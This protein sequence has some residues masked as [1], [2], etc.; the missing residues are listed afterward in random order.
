VAEATA[1]PAVM[2]AA[3]SQTSSALLAAV[4]TAAAAT[5]QPPTPTTYR[6]AVGSNEAAK[7]RE[8]M[9]SEIDS[10]RKLGTFEMV[11]LPSNRK[12]IGCRWVYRIKVLPDGSLRFKARLVAQ[13]FAMIENVDYM[14]DQTSAPVVAFDT[15]RL[16]MCVVTH[17]D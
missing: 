4:V 17:E 12:P 16:F 1:P 10:H 6:E 11:V 9:E 3:P 13:G 8:A 5:S 15:V 2:A 14:P 7:W